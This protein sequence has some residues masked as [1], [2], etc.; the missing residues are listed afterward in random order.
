MNSDIYTFEG[1]KKTASYEA[2]E[3]IALVL[4]QRRYEAS[5]TTGWV[6]DVG[7]AVLQSLEKMSGNFKYIVNVRIQPK[8]AIGMIFWLS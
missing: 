1:I 8:A 5:K 2:A 6:K 7:C 3:A 4:D